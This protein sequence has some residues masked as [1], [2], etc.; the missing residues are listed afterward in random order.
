MTDDVQYPVNNDH[1]ALITLITQFNA[2]AKSIENRIAEDHLSTLEV[3][4]IVEEQYSKL[5]DRITTLEDNLAKLDPV[6][7]ASLKKD[8]EA[9]KLWIHDFNRTK[10]IAW[11]IASAG[12]IG[13]GYY[14]PFFF[15]TV[16][17][18]I[19]NLVHIK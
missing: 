2:T 6:E 8:V 17:G 11:V 5:G 10:H 3:K 9:T 16:S 1:D 15:N 18:F 14:I 12:F 19:W 13:I 4:K 7:I